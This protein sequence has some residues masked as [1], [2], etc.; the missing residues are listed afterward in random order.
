MRKIITAGMAALTLGA[1]MA[2]TA[3]PAAA[4]TWHNGGYSSSGGHWNGNGGGNHWNGN[5]GGGH[6]GYDNDRRYRYRNNNNSTGAAIA[7]GIVGLA[8][9]AALSSNNHGYS[10]HGYSRPYYGDSYYDGGYAVCTGRRE[11]WDP[12]LG[13]YIVQRFNY[14]C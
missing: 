3:T 1:A 11:V 2:A 4:Q 6:W 5:N 9:G 10:N 7:G 13:A 14:A 12:Y 8:L